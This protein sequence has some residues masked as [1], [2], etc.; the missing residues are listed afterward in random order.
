MGGNHARELAKAQGIKAGIESSSWVGDLIDCVAVEIGNA[1][2]GGFAS[3]VRD[4]FIEG[5]AIGEA[6]REGIK[7]AKE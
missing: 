2:T 7:K 4:G 6:I 3:D 1:A 5:H